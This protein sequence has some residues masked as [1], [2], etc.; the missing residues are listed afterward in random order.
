MI[1]GEEPNYG[2]VLVHQHYDKGHPDWV[3]LH[4]P[5]N[6]FSVVFDG[7][8]IGMMLSGAPL[9]LG[10]RAMSQVMRQEDVHY[11]RRYNYQSNTSHTTAR[12]CGHIWRYDKCTHNACKHNLMYPH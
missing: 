11:L 1:Q 8:S 5:A 9:G 10:E 7:T 12:Y 3:S 4:D 2:G 6:E